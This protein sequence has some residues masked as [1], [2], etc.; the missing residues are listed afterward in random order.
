MQKSPETAQPT[1]TPKRIALMAGSF[2]PFTIGHASIV[3]RGLELFDE[4]VVAVG[5]HPDK[6]HT[7][8]HKRADAIAAVYSGEPRVR[9]IVS[10]RL[11]ADIAREVGA[12]FLLRGVRSV[13]DFEYER[14]MAD[15]NREL[16]E[17]LETVLLTALPHLSALSSSV[18]RDIASYGKDVS[19]YL[20]EASTGQSTPTTDNNIK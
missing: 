5:Q 8:A 11:T 4:V 12:R 14:D 15:V 6:P 18:V 3:E 10:H 20:P 16:G 13:R 19:R 9:V 7:D 17:G 2:N 1:D